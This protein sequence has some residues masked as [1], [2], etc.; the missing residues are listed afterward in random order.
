MEHILSVH[1]AGK[2]PEKVENVKTNFVFFIDTFLVVCT[3][4]Y[5][6]HG[7]IP[8]RTGVYDQMEQV[9]TNRKF[10]FCSH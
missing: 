10:H 2:F 1:P 5:Q 7:R 6:V 4:L 3:S 8:R 9:F